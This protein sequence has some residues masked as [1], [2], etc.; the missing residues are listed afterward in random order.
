VPPKVKG[1]AGRETAQPLSGLDVE[2]LLGQTKKTT[3]SSSNSIPD[4]KQALSLTSQENEIED[5]SKQMSTIIRDLIT[6]STGDVGYGRAVEN[7][8]VMRE[9][10][11]S[12]EVSSIGTNT[13]SYSNSSATRC[14]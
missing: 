3:I 2:K 8:R 14:R 11:I 6:N 7:M 4:Y 9:E 5:L 10:L 12:F 13:D 1:K